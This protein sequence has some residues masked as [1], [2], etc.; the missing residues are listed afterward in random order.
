MSAGA[1]STANA[2][3]EIRHRTPMS[4]SSM[5]PSASSAA[6]GSI[7][8]AT[9]IPPR[10]VAPTSHSANWPCATSAKAANTATLET[11]S[12]GPSRA[13]SW[14]LVGRRQCL[15]WVAE[16]NGDVARQADGAVRV[17]VWDDP[18]MFCR[19]LRERPGQAFPRPR[20]AGGEEGKPRSGR[21]RE[22]FLR[23]RLV[24]SDPEMG[25]GFVSFLAA[26]GVGEG[27][28]RLRSRSTRDR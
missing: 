23:R 11:F 5:A 6:P 13:A 16:H 28:G 1:T 7:F 10:G 22:C 9:W 15:P 20:A 21:R 2:G 4:P 24:V 25:V 12:C 26:T 8:F 3:V 27:S 17:P 19:A 18:Q 14:C